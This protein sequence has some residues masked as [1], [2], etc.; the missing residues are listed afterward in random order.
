[1]ST[2]VFKTVK[3][4]TRISIQA[5][6][7]LKRLME[8]GDTIKEPDNRDHWYA[9]NDVQ[10]K[11]LEMLSSKMMKYADEIQIELKDLR[12]LL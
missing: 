8:Q 3:G 4:I 1:M 9:Q 11:T 7:A 10:I 2:I 12:Y 5:E 6:D